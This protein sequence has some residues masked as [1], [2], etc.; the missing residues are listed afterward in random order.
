MVGK[1]GGM[2]EHYKKIDTNVVHI[3]FMPVPDYFV[4]TANAYVGILSY[5]S[6]IL[7]NAYCAPNKIYEYGYFALPM[8]GND[9]PGLRYTIEKENAGII[10]DEEDVVSIKNAIIKIDANYE[11][12]SKAS[13][14]L[15]EKCDNRKT[16][17]ET[18]KEHHF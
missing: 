10:I 13:R 16:I 14:D 18:L 6:S 9:I 1:D 5:D 7:N 3:D 12:F 17:D 4:F 2:V 8:I 11:E 15:F